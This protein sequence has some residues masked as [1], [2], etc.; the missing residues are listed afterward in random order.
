[1]NPIPQP[2]H[3]IAPRHMI[4]TLEWACHFR[5]QQLAYSTQDR[6]G[7]FLRGPA[8]QTMATLFERI[9]PL[10]EVW[11]IDRLEVDLGVL[12]AD[13]TPEQWAACLADRLW[14]ALLQQRQALDG[15]GPQSADR[16]GGTQP[17]RGPASPRATFW[18]PPCRRRPCMADQSKGFLKRRSGRNRKK[19]LSA[20]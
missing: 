20:E 3:T 5:N 17:Q 8:L 18:R 14:D 4:D 11:Q 15:N 6:L 2:R 16:A 12:D 13:A 9:S 1:M 19:S 10:D 7:T